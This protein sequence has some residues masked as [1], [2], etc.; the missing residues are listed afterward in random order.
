M[1]GTATSTGRTAR[2]KHRFRRFEQ[3]RP[4][5]DVPNKKKTKA[6]TCRPGT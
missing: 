1:F 6:N 2:E 3:R 5:Q 4:E